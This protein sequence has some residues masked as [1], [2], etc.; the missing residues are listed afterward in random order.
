MTV[1]DF[2]VEVAE[3][4][5]TGRRRFILASVTTMFGVFLLVLLV[6]A[7]SS[8]TRGISI[9]FRDIEEMRLRISAGTTSMT[10][11][12]HD[13]GVPILLNGNDI[14][15]LQKRFP[16]KIDNIIPVIQKVSSVAVNG[17]TTHMRCYGVPSDFLDKGFFH[18]HTFCGSRIGN[19]DIATKNKVCLISDVMAKRYF[20]TL[21]P[22]SA[23]SHYIEIDGVL[24]KINGI[25]EGIRDD[26]DI[27]FILLPA[28]TFA[29]LWKMEDSYTQILLKCNV[30]A[31]DLQT[32]KGCE[33]FVNDVYRLIAHEH[34]FDYRDKGAL[35]IIGDTFKGYRQAHSI[36]GG[37]RMTI[38]FL[39]ILI[40]ISEIFGVSNILFI[41]V[42]ERTYEMVL[43][44]LMGA[45]DANIFALVVCESVIIMS[46]SPLFGIFLAEGVLH[47]LDSAVS[48][49]GEGDR[50]IWGSFVVDFRILVSVIL[51]TI[52]SGLIAGLAPARR[53]VKLK[54]TEVH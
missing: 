17:R 35:T 12:T 42:R 9:S 15:N 16:D 1:A 11:K 43:R 37:V 20:K 49:M 2:I 52:V 13:K 50:G 21:N 29:S 33:E 10:Y 39:C 44:R 32:E 8:V 7:G 53:A 36:L 31:K 23:I 18:I 25:F 47:L 26:V 19:W 5:R 27:N 38:L 24:F 34:S 22:E 46:V 40:L 48:S 14:R 54:I 45:S 41:S 4:F 3:S 28:T 51:A 30:N 6:G